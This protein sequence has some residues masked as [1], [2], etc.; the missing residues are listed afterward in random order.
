MTKHTTPLDV[1]IA[2]TEAW[3][4]QDM[5]TAAGYVAEGVLFEGPLQQS[6]GA[7]PYLK[8]LTGLARDVIGFRMISAFG[9]KDQALLMYDLI[10]RPYGTLTC[11]KHLTVRGGK[12]QRD[13]LTFDSHQIRKAKA[14]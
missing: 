8:G 10:T 1:A 12:I 14:A 3:T 2:F 13:K 5:K 7:E 9:D 11:A 4:N 6:A